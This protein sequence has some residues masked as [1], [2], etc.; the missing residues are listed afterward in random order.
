VFFL[1]LFSLAATSTL[2]ASTGA[3]AVTSLSLPGKTANSAGKL[4]TMLCFYLFNYRS[5]KT[6]DFTRN[7]FILWEGKLMKNLAYYYRFVL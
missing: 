2:N 1:G 6:Q 7:Y 3:R 5:I 4:S